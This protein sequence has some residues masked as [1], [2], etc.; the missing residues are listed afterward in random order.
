MNLH[1]SLKQG[2]AVLVMFV[3]LV[4]I[5]TQIIFYYADRKT[6]ALPGVE[7]NNSVTSANL[8]PTKE[9]EQNQV[10]KNNLNKESNATPEPVVSQEENKTAIDLINKYTNSSQTAT[11]TPSAKIQNDNTISQEEQKRLDLIK[12]TETLEKLNKQ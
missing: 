7:V 4:L 1:L 6:S 9:I 11:S 8:S 2:L 3:L 5:F 10:N 12:L